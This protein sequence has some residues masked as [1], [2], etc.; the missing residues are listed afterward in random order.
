MECSE[1]IKIESANDIDLTAGGSNKITMTSNNILLNQSTARNFIIGGDNA[2]RMVL[3]TDSSN[4]LTAAAYVSLFGTETHPY[5]PDLA[6]EGE[7]SIAGK[8]IK[9]STNKTAGVNYGTSA[10]Y[11]DT[12]QRTGFDT[13]TLYGKVTIEGT[14][15]TELAINATAGNPDLLFMTNGTSVGQLKYVIGRTAMDLACNPASGTSAGLS[16]TDVVAS[17]DGT[18][19]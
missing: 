18:E 1:P 3:A 10:L 12:A 2:Y 7:I 16:G 8:Y 4:T 15:E 13:E 9:L 6:R 19:K 17:F 14:S 11:I 5:T